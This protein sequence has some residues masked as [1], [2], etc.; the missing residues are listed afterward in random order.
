MNP[1][2]IGRAE[3]PESLKAL[4][5]PITVVVPDRQLIM[6][7]MLMAEVRACAFV[8]GA[9][10]HSGDGLA[11]TWYRCTG[12]AVDAAATAAV[13]LLCVMQGFVEAKM[14]AKK[15]ASLYYLLEDLL[16]PQKHYDWGLRAIKSVLVVAG[17][18]LRAE[19]GQLESNVLFRALRDLN[20]AKILAQVREPRAA[21]LSSWPAAKKWILCDQ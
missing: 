11:K 9:H 10:T 16:S 21:L 5:R 12:A 7:N 17:S 13:H 15:F 19:E 18:L 20:I 2:Y 6:E 1:G 3:L 4:F 14:L 8:C